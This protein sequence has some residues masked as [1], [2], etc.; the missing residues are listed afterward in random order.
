[1]PTDDRA[2]RRNHRDPD[3]I[4]LQLELTPGRE[5]R[6]SIGRGDDATS[7]PFHGWIDFMAALS[8]LRDA[9][10]APHRESIESADLSTPSR[11]QV[12]PDSES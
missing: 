3:P 5:L 2:P 7:V 11:L 4:V 1:V 12:R 8:L 6:G 9:A 10:S